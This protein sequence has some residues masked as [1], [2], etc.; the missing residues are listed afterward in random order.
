[1]KRVLFPCVLLLVLLAVPVFAE[2]PRATPCD[3]A[4]HGGDPR[5]GRAWTASLDAIVE[6]LSGVR[7]TDFGRE[8]A[9]AAIFEY[10]EVFYNRERLHSTLGY[11]TPVEYEEAI[12]SGV[13][14]Y[15]PLEE[16]A[17]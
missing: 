5:R 8:A 2:S 7:R 3:F 17:L 9:Q 14:E 6:G 10:M 13:S 15:H 12:S 4:L 1:M 11:M 16:N